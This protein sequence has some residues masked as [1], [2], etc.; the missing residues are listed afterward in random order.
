MQEFSDL[1][2]ETD[3]EAVKAVLGFW[4]QLYSILATDPD[5]KVREALHNAHYQI[6]LK[7]KRIIAPYLKQLIGPWFTALYD[8]YPPAATAASK[9]FSATFPANKIQ[10]C[11]V[12]CQKEILT[13]IDNNLQSDVNLKQCTNEEAEAKYERIIVSTLQGYCLYLDTLTEEQ[14]SKCIDLN[15]KIITTTRFLNLATHQTVLIRATFFKTLAVLYNKAP[16]LLEEN[17]AQIIPL[18]FNNL[19]ESEPSVVGFVWEAALLIM[20]SNQVIANY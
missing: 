15:R 19:D 14:I 11:V 8:N 20:N 1:I 13:Y 4:A 6:I 2:A 5:H 16:F 18:I 7:E 17:Q 10:D 3:S 12:F 9:A